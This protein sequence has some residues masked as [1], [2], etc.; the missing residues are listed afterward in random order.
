[1]MDD[2]NTQMIHS[3]PWPFTCLI[4]GTS[5][6]L[7]PIVFI[8]SHGYTLI[9]VIILSVHI[10]NLILASCSLMTAWACSA[11][12]LASCSLFFLVT[13]RHVLFIQLRSVQFS[14][15]VASA[16]L[17]PHGLQ[18][19]RPPCPSPTPRVYPNSCPLSR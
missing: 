13:F 11:C 8:Y 9:Q 15:S 17:Q 7:C 4:F 14:C 1:M 5:D 10:Q 18:H 2:I 3:T 12:M 16:S 6:L 19:P